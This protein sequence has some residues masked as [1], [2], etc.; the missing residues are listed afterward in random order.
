GG[1]LLEGGRLAAEARAV[2]VGIVGGADLAVREVGELMET[3]QAGL[4]RECHLCMGTH[5]H[6]EHRASI[7]VLMLVAEQWITPAPKP[8][9]ETPPDAKHVRRGSRSRQ[10]QSQTTL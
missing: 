7:D 5:V 2:L 1:T 8:A 6:A 4:G 9:V 3:I 10:K